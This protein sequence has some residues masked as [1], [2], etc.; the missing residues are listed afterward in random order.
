MFG[1][2]VSGI[3]I[4]KGRRKIMIIAAFIGILGCCITFLNKF[5]SVLVGMIIYGFSCGLLAVSMPRVFEET[6]T[7]EWLWLYGGLYCFSMSFANLIIHIL[8]LYKPKITPLLPIVF[9][10]L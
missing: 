5:V 1:A 10:T 4:K 9:F 8:L 6:I 7:N 2:F 3:Y